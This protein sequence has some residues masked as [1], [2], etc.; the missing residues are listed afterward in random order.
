MRG[1]ERGKRDEAVEGDTTQ[2]VDIHM[3]GRSVM[4]W[5]LRCCLA[6]G[7]EGGAVECC[8]TPSLSC[9]PCC[10]RPS[11]LLL[12]LCP[13]HSSCSLSSLYLPSRQV[14][15]ES[16]C[17]AIEPERACGMSRPAPLSAFVSTSARRTSVVI[18]VMM[19]RVIV[20]MMEW[21]SIP[22]NVL[23]WV[24]LCFSVFLLVCVSVCGV[25]QKIII[26]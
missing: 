18:I 23:M 8:A 26:S 25:N 4:Y 7:V 3:G 13:A 20:M 14:S 17:P 15:S 10:H 12:S 2:E 21:C 24:G 1:R 16:P 5:F 9:P 22:E 19:I 6:C 11:L